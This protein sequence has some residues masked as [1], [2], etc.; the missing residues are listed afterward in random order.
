M[1]D[2]VTVIDPGHSA[3]ARELKD[4]WRAREVLLALARRDL[5]A[6]YK[7][8]VIGA[9]WAILQPVVSIAIFSVVFGALARV[10]SDGRPYPLFAFAGMV[11]W[12]QFAGAVTAGANSLLEN[13]A[14]I[15]K[16]FFPRILLPLAPLLVTT[17]DAL[18][19]TAIL[20]IVSLAYGN[21]PTS[22][23]LAVAPLFLLSMTAALGVGLWLAGLCGIY[24][25]VRYVVPFLL[26]IWFFISPIV[27]PSSLVPTGLRSL[28]GLNPMVGV[29]EGF[30]WAL[31][32]APAPPL[33]MMA[34]SVLSAAVLLASGIA[35]F[36]RVEDRT[37]DVL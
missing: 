33:G 12:L 3:L 15:T 2:D 36:R 34:A 13:R 5:Q 4:V 7:Q 27:Y 8:A 20:V 16:V 22:T 18:I 29:A 23:L 31:V 17:V 6:R 19:A 26:Q 21:A 25:D 28:Y 37:I 30:R 10:P 11:P 9:G 35:F 24:R 14:I 1:R 32:G